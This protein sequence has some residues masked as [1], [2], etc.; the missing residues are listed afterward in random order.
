MGAGMLRRG[1]RRARARRRRRGA[2]A[3]PGARGLRRAR[4]VERRVAARAHP[5]RRR[6]CWRR[7]RAALPAAPRATSLTW[8]RTPG[9]A[10]RAPTSPT[11]S[12]P[13]SAARRR[14]PRPRAAARRCA[15]RECRWR[16]SA[17]ARRAR[18][19]RRRRAPRRCSTAL[20]A[21]AEA[22][23]TAP[24][25][26]AAAVLDPDDAADARA[27]RGAA[28]AR[29]T[30]CARSRAPTRRSSGPPRTCSRRSP[31]C[32]VREPAAPR[33][34]A[35][36]R[37]ARDPRAPLP[38]GVRVRPPGGR[39]PA[40]P[41]AGAVPR[42]RRAHR[43]SRGPAGSCCRATR[44]CSRASGTCSTPRVSRPEEVLFLSFRSS[45]EEG[46]PQQ[47]SPFLDDVRALFTDEL[48]ERRGRRL[49]AEVTWPPAEA[50]TPHELRRAQAA[51]GGAARPGAARR[52]AQRRGARAARGARDRVGARAGDVRGLRRCAGSSSACCARGARSPDPEPMRRGSLAHAVLERTLRRLRERDGSARLTP[53]DAA[54]ALEELRGRDRRAARAAAGDPRARAAA[55]RAGGGPRR[56]LRHE[57]RCGAGLEPA[58]ARVELRRRGRRARPAAAPGRARRRRPRRPDRRRRAAARSSATTRAARSRPARAGPRTGKLQAALYALAARELLGVE[59]VGALYQPVGHRDVRPRGLV[60]DD[61]PGRY[62]NGD[63]VDGETFDAALD[64]ARDDRRHAPRPTCAPAGSAP[65]RTRARRWAAAPT[66][67]SAA[68]AKP[69]PRAA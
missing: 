69:R 63:V 4:R 14:G 23:W 18:G 46:E 58:L 3:R 13:A 17:A 37:P 34:R 67:R 8:L 11:P 64:E 68:R 19:R 48:W 32:E 47:P 57:A 30:S 31:R 2:G 29:R 41:A 22:I 28:R 42:R 9:P 36:R 49:L 40:P 21:E 59:P 65:A 16:S 55:A 66:P 1:H 20:V 51:D 43:A 61:V 6:A 56:L 53:G 10:R 27:A 24:H 25:R 5:A 26:R 52:A 35:A 50:P 62:V 38:R 44:T 54:A 12:T 33:R 15:T 45:D 60:R 39:V 7:A